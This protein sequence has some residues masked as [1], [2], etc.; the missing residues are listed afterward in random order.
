MLAQN[1]LDA[2]HRVIHYLETRADYSAWTLRAET[3]SAFPFA[4]FYLLEDVRPIRRSAFTETIRSRLKFD[5][6]RS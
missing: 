1:V 2:R 3:R 5:S 4:T 6:T